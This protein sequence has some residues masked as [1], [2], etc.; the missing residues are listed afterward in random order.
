MKLKLDDAGHVIVREDKPVYVHDDGKEIPFDAAKAIDTIS[1]LNGEAKGHREAKEAALERL[2]V[3]DGISDPA[4]AIKALEIVANLDAK[5]LVDAGEIDKVKSEAVKAFEEKLQAQEAKY[6]PV[7]EENKKLKA[8]FVS[9]K[10]GNA[11]SRSKFIAEKVAVPADIVQAKFGA[12]FHLDDNGSIVALDQ[13]GA[14]MFSRVN[15]G[16]VAGFDEA[17][18]RLVEAYP[19]REQILKGSGAGGGGAGGGA[20]GGS[21]RRVTRAAYDSMPPHEQ[22]AVARQA[23]TG[24]IQIVD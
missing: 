8:S 24:E 19:F 12:A 10:I 7:L 6:A 15:P 23:S 16:E 11:F 1:R 21:G 18:E 5:K 9:E 20:G 2:K 22:A 14:K 3:F 17:L 4:S 13:G